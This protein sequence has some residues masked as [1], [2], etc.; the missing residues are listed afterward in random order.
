MEVGKYTYG[1]K[2]IKWRE[3]DNIKINNNLHLLCS[4]NFNDL[5]LIE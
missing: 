2:E 4:N 1:H 3:L 5:F